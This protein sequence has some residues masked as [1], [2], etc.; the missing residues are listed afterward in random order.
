MVT[1]SP[2]SR[3]E[4]AVTNHQLGYSSKAL[5]ENDSP[6]RKVGC[7][8]CLGGICFGTPNNFHLSSWSASIFLWMTYG[9]ISLGEDG[10]SGRDGLPGYSFTTMLRLCFFATFEGQCWMQVP[11]KVDVIRDL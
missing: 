9:S 5:F 7:V 3:I 6:F 8:S 10:G 4:K 1:M 2:V 11:F